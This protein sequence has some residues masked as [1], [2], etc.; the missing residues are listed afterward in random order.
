MALSDIDM[1]KVKYYDYNNRSK[2]PHK[3]TIQAR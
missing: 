3:R 2:Y 1:T